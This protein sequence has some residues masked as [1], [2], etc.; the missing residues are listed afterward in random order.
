MTSNRISKL[1]LALV[2][3]SLS[4]VLTGCSTNI[5]VGHVGIVVSQVGTD[6]GVLNAPVRTGKVFYNPW[7]ETVIEYPTY[8]QTAVWTKDVNE[9]N[10]VDESVTFTNK[11][12][13]AINAD[14]SLSYSLVA[15]KVPAFYV[16]FHS[17]DLKT[18]T[19]G[20][21]RNVTRDCLNETAGKYEISQL[22]GDNAKFIE[23]SK[24]C[25]ETALAP[26]G[27]HIDQFGIIGSPR[28]PQM[29]IDQINQKIQADQIALRKQ[30]E[31]TQVTADA[32]KQIA[33]AEGHAKAQIAEANGDAEANRI[34]SASITPAILQARA[35]DNQH[36]MIWR[37]NGETPTTVL[38]S[39]ATP[40]LNLP[41]G[42]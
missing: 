4:V 5:G 24:G 17:D 29:V 2:A 32:A 28:P 15:D 42:K 22:I 39:G 41:S 9:G 38:G 34:R 7:T 26:Y 11:E 23:D 6:K 19:G 37:W 3:L 12:S 21:M 30:M 40:L 35:L 25:V 27:V 33:A 8:V 20:F 14:V 36:D 1:L 16:K 31:L 10:P 13:M 18:F